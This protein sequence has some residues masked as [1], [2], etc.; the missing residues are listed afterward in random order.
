[1]KI[2]NYPPLV[3]IL[4]LLFSCVDNEPEIVD[5]PNERIDF[6]YD[7]SGE[8]NLDFLIGSTIN[9]RNLSEANGACTWDFGDGTIST[10]REPTH[11]YEKAGTYAVTL[12]IEGEG[13]VKKNLLIS[14]IIPTIRMEEIDGVC[15][16]KNTP[17]RLSLSLPN[18]Q[19][20]PVELLWI[21]PEGTTD[22]DGN[23]VTSTTN[24]D[25]GVLRF[26]NVG[27]Q[28]VVLQAK[29]GGRTLEEGSINVQVGYNKPVKT[30]Y[31][32][33]KGGNIMAL[34]LANDIPDDVK[35]YPFD[36]GVKSGQHPMNILFE[37]SLLYVLDAGKQFIY[38]G[39][40]EGL[41]DGNIRVISSNGTKVETMLD[42]NGGGAFD[43]P[44]YGY[45]SSSE[46]ALYFADRNTGVAKI[47]LTQRNSQFNRDNYPYFFQNAALHYYKT[48]M[49][50]GCMN[51]SFTK[52]GDTW[53][54]AKTY[55]GIGIFR[56]TNSDILPETITQGDINK[57]PAA[58]VALN[59]I[60]C[61]SFV[62]DPDRKMVYFA[63]QD[64]GVSGFYA[65][66]FEQFEN[67]SDRTKLVPANY[68]HYTPLVSAIEGSSGEYIDI[69]QMAL[70][71][72][73]GNVYFGYR[74]D[75]DSAV[76]SG[77]KKYNLLTNELESLIDNV[78]IYGVSINNKPSKLF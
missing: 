32:A 66:T 24:E 57:L 23:I 3:I 18:P 48:R 12:S 51:A 13:S 47:P 77:L 62:V 4:L 73:T 60:F 56:F 34:K 36:L 54:W 69:C 19:N 1:M 59:S 63:V 76:K 27:S 67:I 31:Y 53:W 20:L 7:I 55:G 58:G 11:V 37:D 68:M 44:Y 46:G 75:A 15:E 49:D 9:F 61:K 6:S 42:N 52:V 33:V 40:P 35:I 14:D 50:Y 10:E 25:P 39:A 41:G 26:N 22:N 17:V 8:Y 64:L 21:F 28:R 5:F 65:C 2:Y 38:T 45:I 71:P 43:D 29:L 30:L 74:K 16:I 78:E 70:D 72:E